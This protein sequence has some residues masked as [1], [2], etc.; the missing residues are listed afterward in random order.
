[1]DINQKVISANT[2]NQLIP[3]NV[4]RELRKTEEPNARLLLLANCNVIER[5]PSPSRRSTSESNGRALG[6][7][8]SKGQKAKNLAIWT[9]FNSLAEH[10][11]IFDKQFA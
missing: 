6:K 2:G 4:F 3:Q 5:S 8:S 7:V 1:M 10:F 11:L 9:P